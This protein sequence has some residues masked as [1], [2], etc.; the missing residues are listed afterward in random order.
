[1]PSR[2]GLASNLRPRRPFFPRADWL[3]MPIRSS[4]VLDTNSATIVTALAS[5]SHIADLYDFGVAMRGPGGITTA[6][7][8]YDIPFTNVPAWGSDPLPDTCPI[9]SGV[10]IAPGSDGHYTVADP[11]RNRVYGLW[12]T[13]NVSTSPGASWGGW[14][15]LNGD[16]R[17]NASGGSTGSG[18]SRFAGVVTAAEITAGRI[19]HALFFSTNIARPSVIRYPARSTDGSNISGVATNATIPE[20]GRVQLDPTINLSAISGITSAELTVGKAL[21]TYGAYCGD[22]GGSRMAFLFEYIGGTNP[23]STYISAGME[24]DYW[25]MTHIPWSSLRVLNQWD[26]G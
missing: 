18:L 20:G 7:P 6:T 25:D 13:T 19:D 9:P 3:W 1:M 21:Q 22:N 16:G 10:G 14:A 24:W 5:G 2:A 23:G 11:V 12:Q 8:R 26:G 4:P 17:D 15:D